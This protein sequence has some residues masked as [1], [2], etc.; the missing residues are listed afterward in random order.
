MSE[1]MVIQILLGMTA[2][3]LLICMLYLAAILGTL[4]GLRK[5]IEG[6]SNDH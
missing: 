4:Q 6:K 1:T 5:H 3:W 2:C